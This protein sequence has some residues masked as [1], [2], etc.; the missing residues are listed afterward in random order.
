MN[1]KSTIRHAR[2]THRPRIDIKDPSKS[3]GRLLL[4]K[5][6]TLFVVSLPIAGFAIWG[7]GQVAEYN[8]LLKE[9]DYERYT[10]EKLESQLAQESDAY[11][12]IVLGNLYYDD[13]VYNDH[14]SP[15]QLPHSRLHDTIKRIQR[16]GGITRGDA[17]TK[18]CDVVIEHLFLV[19]WERLA[20]F[21]FRTDEA[22]DP[23]DTE[24]DISHPPGVRT[25]TANDKLMLD[26]ESS[27][28]VLFDNINCL[29]LMMFDP[30]FLPSE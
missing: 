11:Y 9:R 14:K 2:I 13:A 19:E 10:W 22:S 25:M 26:L 15:T 20:Y 3:I 18:Y 23:P 30:S 4:D 12:E 16:Y 27:L 5:L 28:D 8:A 24:S 29:K 7:N 17:F 6:L 21:K 1:N